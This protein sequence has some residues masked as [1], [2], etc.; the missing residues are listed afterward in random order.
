MRFIADENISSSMVKAIRRKGYS[1][2]DIKEEGLIGAK[3]TLVM[4]ISRK[5]NRIIITFD[6][7]FATYPLKNHSGVV[8]LRYINK[9]AI[10]ATKQFCYL[11]DSP[12]KEKFE[13]SL[14]EVFD[15]G[16]KVHTEQN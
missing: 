3:D 16:V 14:C 10:N 5:E 13:N 12:I 8:L 1:V 2:K 6:K 7:D 9:S 11:L 4:E 15:N